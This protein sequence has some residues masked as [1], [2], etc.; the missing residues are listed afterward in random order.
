MWAFS[1]ARE[2]RQCILSDTIMPGQA[3]QGK[4]RKTAPYVRAMSG[5]KP[6]SIEGGYPVGQ[7]ILWDGVDRRSSFIGLR[8]RW[9]V[10]LNGGYA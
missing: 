2:A 4:S 1:S 10:I 5:Q 7:G 9:R 6:T 8:E 3:C